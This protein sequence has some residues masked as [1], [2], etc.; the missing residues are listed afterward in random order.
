MIDTKEFHARAAKL[1]ALLQSKLGLK[2]KSLS[3]RLRRAGRL[4]PRRL[5]AEAAILTE[6]E[7]KLTHPGLAR[8]VDFP[9]VTKA[10]AALEAHLSEV[11][12]KDRRKGK[13]LGWAGGLVFNLL[14]LIALLVLILRWQGL[15]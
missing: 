3:A 6:A 10:F 13:I 14:V 15:V 8:Q 2:G 5:R 12:P 9:R 4:L 1:E 11:D 7:H